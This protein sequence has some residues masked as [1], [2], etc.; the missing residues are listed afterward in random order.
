[1]DIRQ[2]G[3]FVSLQRADGSGAGRKLRF[4]EGKLTGDVTCAEG[5]MQ[6]LDG[7]QYQAGVIE[8][9]I[10]DEPF[11]A[12]FAEPPDA[13]AQKGAARRGRAASSSWCRATTA[14]EVDF[15]GSSKALKLEGKGV[16]GSSPAAT[17]ASSPARSP[18][19]PATRPRSPAP[20]RTGTVTPGR[21]GAP[22]ATATEKVVAK[23]TGDFGKLLAAFFIAVAIC[24]MLA[25]RLMGQL[26][27]KMGRPRA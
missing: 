5:G 19:P 27:A 15:S 25:A 20:P 14:G 3:Q 24:V 11:S 10:G 18:A 6:P 8:G 2:S 26:A 9:T 21:R 1:M 23:N 12:E 16:T 17:P 7:A 13:G 22:R 4:E